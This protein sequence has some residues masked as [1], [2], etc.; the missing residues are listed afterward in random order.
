MTF[1][2]L[3]LS[4]LKRPFFLGQLVIHMLCVGCQSH[5]LLSIFPELIASLSEIL[6]LIIKGRQPPCAVVQG[7]LAPQA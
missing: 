7:W 6:L 4:S 5:S 1:V 2:V 3:R